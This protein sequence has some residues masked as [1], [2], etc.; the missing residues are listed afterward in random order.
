MKT[1]LNTIRHLLVFSSITDTVFYYVEYVKYIYMIEKNKA[2]TNCKYMKEVF[3]VAM[4]ALKLHHNVN[5]K[6]DKKYP[7]FYHLFMVYNSALKFKHLLSY[8]DFILALKIIFLHDVIEDARLTYN[9]VK[10]L[11]G[12]DVADGVFACTELRGKNRAERHGKDYY[13]L[14]VQNPIHVFVKLCDIHAN[15]SFGKRTGSSMFKKYKSEYTSK[16]KPTLYNEQFN[17]IFVDFETNLFI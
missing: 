5:Q 3:D 11:F 14:L 10:E 15:V 12:K 1:L 16:V 2:Q 17:D 8:D 4:Y 13:D 7:Y 6:Y 9:D